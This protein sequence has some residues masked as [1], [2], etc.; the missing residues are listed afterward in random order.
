M[1]RELAELAA[2]GAMAALAAESAKA[3]WDEAVA[4]WEGAVACLGLG[5]EAGMA[6]LA[7]FLA[8]RS[9]AIDAM[10]AGEIAR[11]EAAALGDIHQVWA[12]R[13]AALLPGEPQAGLAELLAMADAALAR[14]AASE[15]TWLAW[16][17]ELRG[18]QRER[19]TEADR[20]A[21]ADREMA[22][23]R[24]T[25]E[26]ILARLGRPAGETPAATGAVLDRIAEL[27]KHTRAAAVARGRIEGMQT[28]PRPLCRAG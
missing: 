15:A 17:A 27:D 26:A 9:A 25:W 7:E 16:Q 5:R 13:L 4:A 10:K 20:L 23:W 8:R 2:Q 1:A 22:E 3:R 24:A 28:I 12:G 18:A 19:Q 21:N 14:A 6:E 11:G